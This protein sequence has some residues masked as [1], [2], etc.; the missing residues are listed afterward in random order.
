MKKMKIK[1]LRM[2]L[3]ARAVLFVPL[4]SVVGMVKLQAQNITFAD[5]N[6][7]TICVDNWDANGDGELSYE[8]AAA[9]T[10][11][12]TV[13]RWNDDI[14]SFD[15]LQYFTGLS[16]I[17][18]YAFD[19]CSNL[20]SIT[21]PNS[22][23]VI[24]V[25][26]FQ[27]CTS[28]ASIVFPNSLVS[29]DAYAFSNCSSLTSVFIPKD[30]HSLN[31]NSYHSSD[32]ES[33][34]G[35]PFYG[36]TSLEEIVVDPENSTF[37]SRNDCNAIIKGSTLIT[38]CKN[39]IIP[40]SVDE[41]GIEAFLSCSSLTSI[42]IPNAV[43]TIGKNSFNG[44][45]GLTSITIPASVTS[46]GNYAFMD[47]TGL[48]TVTILSPSV[49][50]LYSGNA[51]SNTSVDLVIYV[52]YE[53]IEDY[54]TTS[55]WSFYESKIKG[56]LQKPVTGYGTSTESDKWAFIA[57]PLSANTAPTA[58]AIEGLIAATATEY[59]LYRFNQDANGLEWQN[60]KAHTGD[61]VFENG[62]GY[63]YA[64]K[65]DANIMFKG[66][67]NEGTSMDVDLDYTEGKPLAGWNLVGNPFPY[68][69][70]VSKS[71]YVMNTEGTGLEPTALSSG[72]SIE[73]CTGVVVKATA[74]GQKV[75]FTKPSKTTKENNGLL[76]IDLV[77]EDKVIVSFNDGDEL[78]KYYFGE[79]NA[80]IYI[81]KNGKE[82]AI[83]YCD[84]QGEMPLNFKAAKNGEYT[85]TVGPENVELNYLHLID[86]MTGAD[87]DLLASPEYTF[88]AK[89]SDYASRLRLVFS[90]TGIEEY[91]AENGFAYFNGS[92]WVV[93]NG[94]NATLQVV[95]LMGRIVYCTDVARN[96]S[97]SGMPA[98][99]YVLRLVNGNNVKVQKVVVR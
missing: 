51:F 70:T 82:Y 31:Y 85:I 84:K 68:P 7:K 74:M 24:G 94:E 35:N 52:P 19:D 39:T 95:D 45:T 4:L 17:G 65:A 1:R 73:A 76:Y 38:G 81:P 13:F 56:W 79:Q 92:E 67:F 33:W 29:I 25:C 10:D 6:V 20:I 83:A 2:N 48:E 16:S 37:D 87:V 53:A 32:P 72:T 22:V 77:N 78:G 57:S 58:T 30:V 36:C 3:V 91:D 46:I 18:R 54:K 62:Q 40:E 28:L 44:C 66:D 9:V 71:Y 49:T 59:D 21:I 89:T 96:V 64:S 55:N 14:T 61:F 26:A 27:D 60:Y 42:T 93:A 8:E 50:T 80:N 47:C 23:L 99:V 90:A 5:A 41:I 98:G 15:E 43:T 69:T 86:N 97:T 11:L 75:T 12:G 34:W 63:L 88:T